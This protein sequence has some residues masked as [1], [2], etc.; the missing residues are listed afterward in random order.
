MRRLRV[1]GIVSFLVTLFFASMGTS[2]ASWRDDTHCAALTNE[3]IE[4]TLQAGWLVSLKDRVTG[5]LLLSIDPDRLPSKMLIF[6]ESPS[7]L[8]GATTRTT[9]S[10]QAVMATWRFNDGKA[11]R[12]RAMLEPD[13]GDLVLQIAS[14]T[15]SPVEQLRYLLF[16]CDIANHALVWIH[17]YGTA[18]TMRAPFTGIQLGDPETTGSPSGHCHPVVALF[19]GKSAGWWIEGRDPRI[20]PANVLVKGT[21]EAATLGMVRRFPIPAANPSLYEIRI[22]AYAK[23]WE[24]AEGNDT[25]QSIYQGRMIRCSSAYKPWRD[26]LI[27]QMKDAVDAG[28]DV[29]YL[30][31]TMAPTGKFVLDGMNG[32]EGIQALMKETLEAYPHVAIEMV[33]HAALRYPALGGSGR[34][35]LLRVPAIHE[36]LD[37]L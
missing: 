12:V 29:I 16:G 4:A 7:D 17:G 23:H 6:D 35:L 33:R 34:T 19:E 9:A 10:G 14:R 27:E 37:R 3:A 26:Y 24:D 13:R 18:T 20:G 15:T 30:D 21:G 31:E 5:E 11:L 25:Y 8:D 1:T 36:G 32:I 28:V 22:R 2:S